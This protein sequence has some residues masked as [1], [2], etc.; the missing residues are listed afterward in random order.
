M[1]SKKEQL[2]NEAI[3]FVRNGYYCSEAILHVFNKELNLELNDNAL[4]MATGLGAGIGGSKCCCGS[5][6]GAVMVLSAVKG[7]TSNT[8]DI[9]EISSLAQEMHDKFKER[10]KSTCCRVLTK[11]VEWATAEHFQFCE[12]YVGGAVDIL[13][14]ILHK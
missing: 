2:T 11:P 12:K 8:E 4:K 10:F 6:T 7:R 3:K 14:D 5:L 9:N 13:Y 1:Q